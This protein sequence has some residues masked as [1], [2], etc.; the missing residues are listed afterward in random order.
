MT[1]SPIPFPISRPQHTF[2]GATSRHPA[3]LAGF[4]AGKTVAGVV[5]TLLL[6]CKYPKLDQGYYFP[7]YDLVK[8][9]GYPAFFEVM[10]AMGMHGDLNRGD[11]VIEVF[12]AGNI[13]F[14][15]MDDPA[16]IVG[17]K[18]AD[19]VVDELDTL[20]TDKAREVWR[21]IL[22][23]NRQ[24]KPDGSLNSAAAVSTPEGFKFMY[25]NWQKSPVE[26]CQLIRASTYSNRRHLPADY[27]PQLLANYPTNLI[28]AYLMGLFVNLTAGSVYPEF[29]RTLNDTKAIAE[30]KETLHIGMDFNVMNMTAVAHV[31]RDTNPHAIGE[32]VKIFDTPAMIKSIKERWPEH[33]IMVYPDASGG[34]RESNNAST[35]DI[36]LLKQ[37]GF[38]VCAP[39][40]NPPVKDRV[41]ATRT[42][43]NKDGVR[44]YRIS[45]DRCPHT[46]EAFEKQAYDK[47][48]EP[49]KSS[50]GHDHPVDACG[51]YIHYRWPIKRPSAVITSLRM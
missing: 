43:I 22:S 15:S 14:R 21:K 2:I 12:G 7:T 10:D 4:G 31:Q 24:K 13:I 50:T 5:R 20:P 41:I 34:A 3:L 40:K 28:Q 30:P 23:R 27:I 36:L 8:T 19:A 6:K 39:S 44:R 29:D 38:T 49:E 25:E 51:Y 47:N 1:Q 26:G 46:V 48:G 16:R 37:A 35:S 9:V 32:L 11:R 33:P 42:M 18:H 17:Y 45:Q